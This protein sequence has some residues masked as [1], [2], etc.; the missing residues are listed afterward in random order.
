MLAIFDMDKISPIKGGVVIVS[1]I[2]N[3]PRQRKNDWARS[4]LKTAL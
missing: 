1:Y 2:E 4:S 3:N